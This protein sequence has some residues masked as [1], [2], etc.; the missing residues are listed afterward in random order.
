MWS[1]RKSGSVSANGFV[2]LVRPGSLLDRIG[3][4]VKLLAERN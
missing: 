4:A 3:L 2:G 1:R